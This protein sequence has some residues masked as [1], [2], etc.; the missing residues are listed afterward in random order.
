MSEIRA[1]RKP[2]SSKISFAASS[3]RAR[4]RAPLLDRGPSWTGDAA[5]VGPDDT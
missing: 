3:S 4:V 2:V 1:L 5:V